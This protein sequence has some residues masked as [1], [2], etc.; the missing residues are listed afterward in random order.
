[1]LKFVWPVVIAMGLSSCAS[2]QDFMNVLTGNASQK[3]TRTPIWV[4][5]PDVVMQVGDKVFYNGTGV[6][7]LPDTGASDIKIWSMVDVDR[8]EISSCSRYDICQK[9]GGPLACDTSRFTV[10]TDWFGNPGKFLTYH[11]LPSTKEH[12]G[13]CSNL[14][15]SI[16]NKNAL[17]AWGYMVFT[18]N[19]DSFPSRM[20]C[21]A[22]SLSFGSDS[23]CAAKNGTIQ[24]ISFDWPIDNFRADDSCHVRK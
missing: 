2:L 24:Q 10:P 14:T 20:S 16:Y 15:I 3:V 4:Y 8:I 13:L 19:K 12:D 9:K 18:T 5:K 6:L 11:Y 7:P 1:M 23:V 22:A 17:A 21:N